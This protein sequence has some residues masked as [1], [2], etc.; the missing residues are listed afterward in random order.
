MAPPL[1]QYEL[2]G[3]YELKGTYQAAPSFWVLFF[4]SGRG[5]SCFKALLFQL[6]SLSDLRHNPLIHHCVGPSH[7][8]DFC[9]LWEW[10]LLFFSRAQGA[11]S[12]HGC[13]HPKGMSWR[14]K[15]HL[16]GYS[17]TLGNTG[18]KIQQYQA[19]LWISDL[20]FLLNFLT[21]YSPWAEQEMMLPDQ[22][23]NTLDVHWFCWLQP[24]KKLHQVNLPRA[25]ITQREVS[26]LTW[27]SSGSSL[28]N[29]TFSL[30]PGAARGFWPDLSCDWLNVEYQ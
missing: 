1:D 25:Q 3:I 9:M 7:A 8:Q 10:N 4:T 5:G 16:L 24:Y 11:P 23:T 30:A 28:A 19:S 6:I 21:P 15:C 2:K 29:T 14:L 12:L 20:V 17:K 18:L 13:L 26:G 22:F 27:V